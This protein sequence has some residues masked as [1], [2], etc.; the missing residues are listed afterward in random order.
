[1]KVTPI[2]TKIPLGKD[3]NQDALNVGF[4]P[5]IMYY[6]GLRDGMP[7]IRLRRNPEYQS[8]CGQAPAKSQITYSST[9]AQLH[10]KSCMTLPGLPSN[11]PSMHPST[12]SLRC[13]EPWK[14]HRAG[15]LWRVTPLFIEERQVPF[16]VPPIFAGLLPAMDTAHR[17]FDLLSHTPG[18]ACEPWNGSPP[19]ASMELEECGAWRRQIWLPL[20]LALSWIGGWSL[21]DWCWNKSLERWKH[22]AKHGIIW[23]CCWE[24]CRSLGAL[25]KII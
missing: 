21:I 15:T 25:L 5:R 20:V 14:D 18:V 2:L 13:L 23:C 16:D 17:W 11:V 7:V 3:K 22:I 19:C 8:S 9:A 10:W 24:W 6:C 12:Q 4:S 1:M